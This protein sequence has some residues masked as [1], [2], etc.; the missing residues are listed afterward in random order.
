MSRRPSG[1]AASSSLGTG[2]LAAILSLSGPAS[3]Q[4]APEEG[5]SP[6]TSPETGA[7]LAEPRLLT[8]EGAGVGPEEPVRA[9][10]ELDRVVAAVEGQTITASDVALEEALASR[11]PSTVPPLQESRATPL[12]ALV[13]RAVL[14]SLAGRAAVY[15]P[16]EP[17]LRD[18]AR[19]LVD[20][21]EDPR[22]WA[23]FQRVHGL[24]PDRLAASLR[25]L[26]IAERYVHRNVGLALPPGASE[27]EYRL[28]YERWMAPRR[29]RA[30]VRRIAATGEDP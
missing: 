27:V 8:D 17:E 30:R 24:D 16:E 3:A 11:S 4:E 13:D 9:A 25:T 18:R 1:G 12:E 26:M 20:S 21:F 19:E 5:T 14:R 10:T 23:E 6:E 15:Q 22:D 7:L 28:A 2:L 29:E